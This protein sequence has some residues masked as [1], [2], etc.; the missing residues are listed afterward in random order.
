MF[1]AAMLPI[2][3]RLRRMMLC[4][5]CWR[6]LH[7]GRFFPRTW[8]STICV[9]HERHILKQSEARRAARKNAGVL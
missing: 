2:L 6:G 3:S 5:W 4:S 8:S 9:R 1:I 7:I